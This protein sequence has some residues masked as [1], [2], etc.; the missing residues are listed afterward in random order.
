MSLDRFAGRARLQPQRPALWCKQRWFSYAE[1]DARAARLARR[2]HTLGIGK[3]DRVAVLALNHA[4]HIDLALAAPRLGCIYTP[5]NYRL[6][7]H[8]QREIAD[9]LR[10]AL[11]FHDALH[12]VLA[13]AC[14]VPLRSLDEYEDWLA[15]ADTAALPDP[16][17][18]P[19]D[20]HMILLT[21]GSTGLPKGAMIPYRQVLANADNTAQGWELREDDCAIQATPCFHAAF[22]V[23]TTPLLYLGGRVILMPQ[24]EP[25]EYLRLAA[26]QRATLL[27]MVPTMFQ[28]LAEHADFANADLSAV[29]W[30]ISG[31]APCPPRIRDLFAARDIRFRQGYGMTEA[32]VNCFAIGLDEAEAHPDAV[33]YPLPNTRVAIRHADGRE[34]A[35]GEVGELTLAGSHVCA[36]YFERGDEWHK[37]FR[38]GWLWTGDLAARDAAG[39]HRIVGRRK[40]MFISGGE[41]VYPAEVEA[42]L[43]QC[44]GVAECA[45][46]GIPHEKWGEVGLAAVALRSGAV[47]DAAALRDELKSRL[48]AYKIP[49]EYWFLPALPKS[50]AGKI[51]KPEILRL[52]QAFTAGNA[53]KIS[54][55][56]R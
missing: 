28:M 38:D 22:N 44:A 41:N 4:L 39:L 47:T 37:S 14:G 26:Q 5:F 6:A 23:F 20:L 15:D 34:C 11:L 56:A 50:G 25:G 16:D 52:Y 18:T 9:Y 7:A 43:S 45:V 21:G 27:F 46:L 10:P 17:L 31:G 30:A 24:F 3:G 33:G 8:E 54:R 12:A 35:D 40:E 13:Q 42:A 53:E 55:P 29:R 32:G 48:A 19:E 51:L 2:L 49:R 36:G 1:L